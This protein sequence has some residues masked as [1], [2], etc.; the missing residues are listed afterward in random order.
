VKEGGY[1]CKATPDRQ[2]NMGAVLSAMAQID[3]IGPFALLSRI[4]KR[5]V[6]HHAEIEI[7][8]NR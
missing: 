2:L 4:A 5:H 3:L 6:C 1:S 8:G 7:D